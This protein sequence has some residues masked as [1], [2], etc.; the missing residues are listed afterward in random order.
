[1]AA[2]E[3]RYKG[4][5]IKASSQKATSQVMWHPRLWINGAVILPAMNSGFEKKLFD[6]PVKAKTYAKESGEWIID[7]PARLRRK[8]N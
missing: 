4:H 2:I 5:R 7:H 8:R 3:Y 1:M 6:D